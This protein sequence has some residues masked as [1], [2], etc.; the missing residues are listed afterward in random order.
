LSKANHDLRHEINEREQ[1]EH[2][3]RIL[4][5]Q[6]LHSQK[7]EAIGILA[8]GIAHD[9]NN[10]LSAMVSYPDLILMKLPKDSPLIKPVL[11]IQNS[12][13]RAAAS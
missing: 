10:L 5:K 8:G 11:T 13:K 3:R 12:G 2:E 9:L 6:L 4:E 7:M 1:L